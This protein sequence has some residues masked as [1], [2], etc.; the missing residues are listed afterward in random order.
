MRHWNRPTCTDHDL[1]DSPARLVRVHC[2]SSWN[3]DVGVLM[4]PAEGRSSFEVGA[5]TAA[6]TDPEG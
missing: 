3:C 6:G 4:E 2:G 1:G 5:E